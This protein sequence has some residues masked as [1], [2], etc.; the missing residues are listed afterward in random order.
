MIGFPM[1][2][3]LFWLKSSHVAITVDSVGPYVL[4]IRN[5]FLLQRTKSSLEQGSPPKIS[6]FREDKGGFIIES[7]V[8]TVE[9]TVIRFSFIN[10]PT[11]TPEHIMSFWT[12][13]N[14]APDEKASHISSMDASN[15][16]EKP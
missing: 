8:G 13:Y 16:S 10:S 6:N 14:A 7:K 1:V 12:G 2:I 9:K 15:A 11:S 4:T 3:F 5:L